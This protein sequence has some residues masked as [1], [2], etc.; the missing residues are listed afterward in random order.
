MDNM[1]RESFRIEE[2]LLKRLEAIEL[3]LLFCDKKRID[4][5]R[6]EFPG[7]KFY[8]KMEALT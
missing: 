7:S 2:C 5:M 1:T 3:K 4:G 6:L 8:E